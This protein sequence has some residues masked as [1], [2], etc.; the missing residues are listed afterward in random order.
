MEE[1]TLMMMTTISSQIVP[2]EVH[3]VITISSDMWFGMSVVTAVT[4][5]TSDIVGKIFTHFNVRRDDRKLR[6]RRR[7]KREGRSI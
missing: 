7:R 3:R 6:R 5:G 4:V 1:P 2:T